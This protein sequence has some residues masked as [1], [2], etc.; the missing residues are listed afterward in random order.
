MASG[1][2]TSPPAYVRAGTTTRCQRVSVMPQ[3]EILNTAT[4]H[5]DY[6]K[7]IQASYPLKNR[8]HA[9]KIR[10]SYL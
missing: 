1:C 7:E 10:K 2:R 9:G 3:S 5:T 4:A 6:Y 8:G